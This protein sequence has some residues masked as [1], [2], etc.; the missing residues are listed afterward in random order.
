MHNYILVYELIFLGY[1][2][3]CAC[4]CAC[5]VMCNVYICMH[6]CTC[7]LDI[8]EVQPTIYQLNKKMVLRTCRTYRM[9]CKTK[10]RNFIISY[11]EEFLKKA[12]GA[13]AEH[14][15]G[16]FNSYRT[17]ETLKDNFIKWKSPVGQYKKKL[18]PTG[19]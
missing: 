13:P 15:K 4:S 11:Y 8:Y 19:P 2:C 17:R 5:M 1:L 14:C 12:R 7:V 6:A 16:N 18:I 10:R 3:A 9:S